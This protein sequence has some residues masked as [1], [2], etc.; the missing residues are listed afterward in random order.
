MATDKWVA[1]LEA[2][3]DALL[4]K[5]G[6]DMAQFDNTSTTTTNGGRGERELTALEQQAIDNAPKAEATVPPA[7]ARTQ[8]TTATNAPDTSSSTPPVP[9]DA[10]GS[11]TVETTQPDGDTNVRTMS[12]DTA[13]RGTQRRT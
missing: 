13:R 12:A 2:K 10:E 8:R 5:S 6:V 9:A 7:D 11:V 3:L 1:R 4:E